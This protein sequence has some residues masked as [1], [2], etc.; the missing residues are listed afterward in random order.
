M[1]TTTKPCF[2]NG[3]EHMQWVARNCDQCWKQSRLIERTG[4]YTTYK[5]KINEQIDRQLMGEMTVYMKT[6]A[7]AQ[8]RDCPGRQKKKKRGTSP[9]TNNLLFP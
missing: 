4:E 8:M 1:R 3:T 5:C 6:Y 7:T 9:K 2:A